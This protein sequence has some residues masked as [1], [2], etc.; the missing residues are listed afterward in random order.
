[1]LKPTH[2]AWQLLI[3]GFDEIIGIHVSNMSSEKSMKMYS[4]V[5]VLKV[6]ERNAYI[7]ESVFFSSKT[8]REV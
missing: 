5:R 3:S 1:M 2:T 4:Q 6:S 8:Y 7:Y